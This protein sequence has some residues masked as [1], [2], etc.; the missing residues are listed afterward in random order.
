MEDENSNKNLAKQLG[1]VGAGFS[2]LIGFI[3]LFIFIS[4]L[5]NHYELPVLGESPNLDNSAKV[6]DF[7]GGVVGVLFS[8]AGVFLLVLTFAEQRNAFKKERF[9]ARYFE[10]L[11]IHLS[12]VSE[13]EIANTIKSRACFKYMINELR[14]IYRYVEIGA[15]AHNLIKNDSKIK[16]RKE[17]LSMAFLIMYFGI[18]Y[19][20]ERQLREMFNEDED[21]IFT[22]FVKKK[23]EEVQ[24]SYSVKSPSYT[25]IYFGYKIPIDGVPDGFT[26]ETQFYPFDGHSSRLGH[27]YRHLYQTVRYVDNQPEAIVSAKEKYEY[28]KSLRATLSNQEQL[29]LYYNCISLFGENW[30]EKGLIQKY[31]FIKNIPLGLVDIGVSPHEIFGTRTPSG[32]FLF[33]SDEIKERRS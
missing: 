27:Y 10:L 11:K 9:E 15:L 17:Y 14:L 2:L 22:T 23:L 21:E 7:I 31:A 30:I 32:K 12:N 5:S 18:G 4:K 13:F 24:E 29:L 33:E 20:S 26:F 28:L 1:L 16:S 8:L 3:I 25:P 6:G 19:S